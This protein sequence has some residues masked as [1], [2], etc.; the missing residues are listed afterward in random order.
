MSDFSVTRDPR[1]ITATSVDNAFIVEFLPIAPDN[2]LKVYIYGLM[3]ATSAN[4]DAADL[5]TA[6]GMSMANVL[7]AYRFWEKQGLVRIID[8]NKINIQYLDVRTASKVEGS[9][10]IGRY[11]E[12]IA[13]LQAILGTRNLCGAELQKIYDWIDIFRFEPDAAVEIVRHCI[14]I[15][16]ARVN[17]NYMDAVAK[18]LAAERYLSYEQ[19]HE[20]F[21]VEIESTSGAAAILKRWRITR[22]PTEDESELYRKWTR[23]WGFNSDA[24]DL[25][26]KDVVASDRPSF[27]YLDAILASYHESGNVSPEKMQQLAH[28]QDMIAE[29]TRRVYVNAGLANRSTTAAHRQ[30]VELWYKDWCM[31]PEL[32]FYAAEQA[33]KAVHPF[34]ETKRLLAAWHE[35]GISTI[36]GAKEF[37][38]NQHPITKVSKNESRRK[39]GNPALSYRQH[40]Y[41]AEQLRELGIDLGEDIYKNED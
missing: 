1:L 27:K 19:V 12:L 5:E 3:L 22:R 30:Q 13:K 10:T 6:L 29:L 14:E 37:T 20:C 31:D 18:R 21:L 8:S 16:G 28:E 32:I 26:C 24:I 15:K 4:E 23:D 38:D 40:Q 7:D 9:N 34:A 17:I 25:A 11:T 39:K 41:T 33:A 35:A 2:A 36:I